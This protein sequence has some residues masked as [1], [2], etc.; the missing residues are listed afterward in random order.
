VAG[1]LVLGAWG[2]FGQPI[3]AEVPLTIPFAINPG[4]L[5]CG[6]NPGSSVTPDYTSPFPF[7]GTIDH[8]TI[9]VSGELTE[10]PEAELRVHLARQ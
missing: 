7:T 10:D 5:A 4:P 2:P 8:V 6:F 3:S 9:D 1:F